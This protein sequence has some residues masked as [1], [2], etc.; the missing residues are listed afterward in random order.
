MAL[1]LTSNSLDSILIRLWL[2]PVLHA[3]V[4][5]LSAARSKQTRQMSCLRQILLL[6]P[7]HVLKG[8][9]RDKY[10]ITEKNGERV[11][12]GSIEDAFKANS[13]ARHA[14]KSSLFRTAVLQTLSNMHQE[15]Y[16]HAI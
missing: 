11:I 4:Y 8:E 14:G 1:P 6:I 13:K 7:Q 16:T 12:H 10:K 2:L 9:T 3:R 5:C 15:N